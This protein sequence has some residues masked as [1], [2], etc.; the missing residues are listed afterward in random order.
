MLLQFSVSNYGSIKNEVILS[1]VPSADREHPE[2]I[3]VS[4]KDRA[5]NLIAIYG[6]NASGKS[7]LFKALTNAI[8]YIRSSNIYQ[9]GQKIPVVPFKFCDGYADIPT[10]F[11]FIFIADNRQKYIY[12]F[13][14]TAEKIFEEYLYVYNTAKPSMLLKGR[15]AISNSPEIR[16]QIF[17]R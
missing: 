14:A 7:T 3:L 10:K 12:G 11:E 13:S 16:D 9:L 2:N 17:S 8:I 15:E 1:L 5:N 6:A 4:G